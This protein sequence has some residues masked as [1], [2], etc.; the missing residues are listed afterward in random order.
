MRI[1]YLFIAGDGTM[2]N[3][4]IE[5]R[6]NPNYLVHRRYISPNKQVVI[7]EWLEL[8][9]VCRGQTKQ[10]RSRSKNTTAMIP[11]FC[12]CWVYHLKMMLVMATPPHGASEEGGSCFFTHEGKSLF[13][14]TSPVT[15]VKARDKLNSEYKV[16]NEQGEELVSGVREEPF[17]WIQIGVSF[18]QRWKCRTVR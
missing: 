2:E 3:I 5:K 12:C 13:P 1:K 6:E 10:S 11:D 8:L 16:Y 14:S 17:D 9:G 7:S 15:Q 18:I 4:F